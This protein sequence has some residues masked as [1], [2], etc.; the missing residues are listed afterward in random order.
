MPGFLLP[1]VRM[2]FI[3]LNNKFV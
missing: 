2:I 1:T 3:I